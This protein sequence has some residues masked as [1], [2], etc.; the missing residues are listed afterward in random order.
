MQRHSEMAFLAVIEPA[1]IAGDWPVVLARLRGS[2]PP[3]RLVGFLAS[4]VDAVARVAAAC[5]GMTGST[6]HC[7]ALASVLQH[8]DE[9]AAAGAADALWSIWMRAGSPEACDRLRVAVQRLQQGAVESA[10]GVLDVLIRF[11]ESFAEAHHQRAIAL[12]SLDRLD[13]AEAAYRRAVALNPFHFAAIAGIG[14]VCVQRDECVAALRHYRRALEIH[15]RL[16]EIREIVPQLEA[17]IQRRVV[18]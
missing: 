6:Q 11:E 17:A 12:H 4:P 7:E 15:P 1:L 14:H 10:L 9:Q 16:A 5:L 13:E 18:A 8:A 3:E 2:W